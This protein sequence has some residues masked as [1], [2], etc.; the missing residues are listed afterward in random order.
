MRT[1][2]ILIMVTCGSRKE[3]ERIIASLLT[4]RVIACGNI[5]SGVESKF[6]W[7]DKVDR[8]SE[9]LLLLKTRRTNFRKVERKIKQIHGYDVPEIIALPIVSANR[10]YLDW[11][12]SCV[13]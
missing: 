7:K 5:V 6:W 8:A 12:D 11:I 10:D 9:I 3:A 13:N 1:D 4:N 2:F